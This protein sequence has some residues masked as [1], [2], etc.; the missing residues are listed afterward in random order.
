MGAGD[1]AYV[2]RRTTWETS[3]PLSSFPCSDIWLLV[4]PH[5]SILWFCFQNL[6]LEF[7]ENPSFKFR[8]KEHK[9]VFLARVDLS[10]LH[11]TIYIILITKGFFFFL[12]KAGVGS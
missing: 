2:A 7:G 10:I 8:V 6:S 4:W 9:Y 12:K 1:G 5:L 3:S 11:V